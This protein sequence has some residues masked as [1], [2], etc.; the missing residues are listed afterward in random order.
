MCLPAKL[1]PG[2][3]WMADQSWGCNKAGKPG[4]WGNRCSGEHRHMRM[5]ASHRGTSVLQTHRLKVQTCDMLGVGVPYPLKMWL[6]VAAP[7]PV[8]LADIAIPSDVFLVHLTPPMLDTTYN[9]I[10]CLTL[11]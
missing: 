8:P 3:C 9:C 6:L 7:A 10:G 11:C 4:P 2:D 5:H 1:S